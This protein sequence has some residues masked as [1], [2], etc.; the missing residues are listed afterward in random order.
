MAGLMHVK[1]EDPA[2]QSLPA[3]TVFVLCLLVALPQWGVT[4]A[5]AAERT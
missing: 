3:F 5:A 4:K 1:V 2:I